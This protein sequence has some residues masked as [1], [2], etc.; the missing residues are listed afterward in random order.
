MMDKIYIP[1]NFTVVMP[2][3]V[4]TSTITE[5]FKNETFI[6]KVPITFLHTA[7]GDFYPLYI[8]SLVMIAVAVKFK[9]PLPVAFASLLTALVLI[10]VSPVVCKYALMFIC[11]MSLLASAYL[12]IKQ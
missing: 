9:N 6:Y 2:N 4:N 7:M 12:Y 3:D 11:A 1:Q 8:Y 10:P 5:S